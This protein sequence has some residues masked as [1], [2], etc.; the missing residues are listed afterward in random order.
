MFREPQKGGA[1]GSSASARQEVEPD[2]TVW[3]NGHIQARLAV[4]TEAPCPSRSL[5][6]PQ[7]GRSK[8]QHCMEIQFPETLPINMIIQTEY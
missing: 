4:W 7:H 8:E 3:H 5:I 2:K 1:E 6:T